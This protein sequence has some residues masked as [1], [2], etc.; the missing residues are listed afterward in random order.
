MTLDEVIRYK[1]LHLKYVS[2]NQGLTDMLAEGKFEHNVPMKNVCA[3]V[4]HALFDDLTATCA[5]LDISKRLFIEAA[6]VEALQ[7]AENILEQEGLHDYLAAKAN[8]SLQI[9]SIKSEA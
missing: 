5:L 9:E 7:K 1:A 4:T 6:L 3:M 8:G 2:G